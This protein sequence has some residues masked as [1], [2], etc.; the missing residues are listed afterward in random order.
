MPGAEPSTPSGSLFH[1]VGGDEWFVGLVD[2]FYDGVETDPVLRPLYAANL[3]GPRKRLAMFLAQYFGGPPSYNAAR[4]HPRLRMR[5]FKFAIGPN[6]RDA[7]LRLMTEA[8]RAGSLDIGD[9]ED[10]LGYF[11]S[12]A[13]M[14]MSSGAKGCM[15]PHRVV[16]DKQE[17][18][19]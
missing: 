18:C 2:R 16:E 4:G 7:W 17:T 10:V 19:P 3:I 1:R 6:E 15:Q 14:L 13:T 11:A 12:T 8:V 5:H 9:E